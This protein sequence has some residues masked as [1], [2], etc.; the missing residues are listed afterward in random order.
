MKPVTLAICV[1]LMI[2]F[3]VTGPLAG[4]HSGE[5]DAWVY[6]TLAAICFVATIVFIFVNALALMRA[7]YK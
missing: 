5:P 4:M 3:P 6:H 2:L 1:V 7:L